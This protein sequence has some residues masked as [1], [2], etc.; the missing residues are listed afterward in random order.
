[1]MQIRAR[2]R[3]DLEEL[4]A[5]SDVEASIL[6]TPRADYRYRV[7]VNRE[8]M[9]RLVAGVAEA[10]SY[11][12]FK[13]AVAETATQA[14]KEPDLH[15]VWSITRRWQLDEANTPHRERDGSTAPRIPHR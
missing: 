15:R 5:G 14:H 3:A 8:D 9:V 13:G 7:I 6:D 1:M 4:L 12:N 11:N 2:T 10:I